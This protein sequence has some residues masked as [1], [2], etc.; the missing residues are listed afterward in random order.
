MNKG[1]VTISRL[2]RTWQIFTYSAVGVAIGLGVVV[3]RI[4]NS[5]SYLSDKPETCVN[6]HVMTYAY[7]TWRFSSHGRVAVCNDCHI[8]HSTACAATAINS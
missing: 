3:A 4:A 8:P 5:V 1:I 2:S 6:C 7:A